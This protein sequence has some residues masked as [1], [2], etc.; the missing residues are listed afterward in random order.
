MQVLLYTEQITP[1]LAY[2]AEILLSQLSGMACQIISD[3]RQFEAYEGPRLNYSLQ[4]F[5]E[6]NLWIPPH[7]LLAETG[8]RVQT[9][10][11]TQQEQVP[12]FFSTTQAGT[13][14]SFDVFA[15]S[16]YLL[17]RYEEYLPAPR[18]AHGR[19]GATSSLAWQQGFLQRPI[20]QEWAQLLAKALQSKYPA[21]PVKPVA[22]TFQPSYDIDLAWAYGHRPWWR[23]VAALG[24]DFAKGRLPMLRNRMAVARGAADPF[25][26]FS[27]LENVHERYDLQP[28]FFFLLGNYGAYDKNISHRNRPFRELIARLAAQHAVGIHPSYVAFENPVQLAEEVA[29]LADIT[30]QQVM[31]SR[32]HFLRLRFPETYRE[33]LAAGIEEDYSLGYADQPGFRAGMAAPFFWYDLEREQKTKLQLHPFQVMDVTLQQYLRFPAKAA[34]GAVKTLSDQVRSTGGTFTT[35]W[36]NSS[37]S[38]LHGWAGWQEVYE[39]ILENSR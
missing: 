4:P 6:K 18:D 16:F 9:C 8:I 15:A 33:L 29:R 1:R 26:T 38:P 3:K 23:N 11:P 25:F 31:R 5:T 2:T 39:Q 17:S 32:Q 27:Y 20:V 35:L 24:A 36:H 7:G 30:G 19:F 12:A 37:F 10:T 13:D 21:L 28:V 14:F 22:Y 34:A